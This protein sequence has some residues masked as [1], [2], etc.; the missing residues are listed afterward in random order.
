MKD[1]EKKSS[2]G[3][4]LVMI[5]KVKLR[6]L[7]LK[8]IEDILT[9]PEY[10]TKTDRW[11][12]FPV[13]SLVEGEG[14]L[15]TYHQP[16]RCFSFGIENEAGQLV[17]RANIAVLDDPTRVGGI[18]SF[19]I[20]PESADKGYGQGALMELL[21]FGFLEQGMSAI[22]LYTQANNFK[23]R[24]IYDKYGFQFMG[25]HYDYREEQGYV[26]FVDLVVWRQSWEQ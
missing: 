26:E 21:R 15:N 8:D 24:H 4:G 1:I 9:W 13:A 16:P 3:E 7:Q 18:F 2:R 22:Y 20:N 25:T 14:W 19:T 11:A 10:Q 5:D 12:N 17:G 23:A 6:F